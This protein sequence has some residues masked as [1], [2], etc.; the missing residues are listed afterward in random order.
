MLEEKKEQLIAW[1]EKVTLFSEIA[2]NIRFKVII[3]SSFSD[4]D[5]GLKIFERP[6][7]R[8][9]IEYFSTF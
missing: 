2:A 5:V 3:I 6:K 7:M 1:R 8:K 9:N 4:V